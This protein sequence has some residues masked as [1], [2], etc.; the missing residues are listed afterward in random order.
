RGRDRAGEIHAR[1][2]REAAHDRSLAGDREAVLV[3]DGRPFDPDRDI[4]IH[5]AGL[6]E[7]LEADVLACVGLADHD[8]LEGRHGSRLRLAGPPPMAAVTTENHAGIAASRATGFSTIGR[9]MV[10]EMR[11]NTHPS[12]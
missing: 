6:V 1:D 3:V 9:L 5:Q 2:H 11:A 12:P 7:V 10:A 4:A 8:R